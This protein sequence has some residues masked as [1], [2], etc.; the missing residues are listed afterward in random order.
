MDTQVEMR[1]RVA[2]SDG[3]PSGINS[4]SHIITKRRLALPGGEASMPVCKK[5][6]QWNRGTNDNIRKVCR[7]REG[8]VRSSVTQKGDS[9]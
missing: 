3:F 1:Q 5:R 4:K 2:L 7:F 8:C 9:P 6:H